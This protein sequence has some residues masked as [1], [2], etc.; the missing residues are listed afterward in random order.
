MKTH[1]QRAWIFA[2]AALGVA[3][4]ARAQ[5]ATPY[6]SSNRSHINPVGA[7]WRETGNLRY[8]MLDAGNVSKQDIGFSLIG[9]SAGGEVDFVIKETFDGGENSTNG[10]GFRGA[11]ILGE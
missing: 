1:L 7:V 5:V 10:T 3:E 11:F 9:E 4:V 8:N 2:L 6:L